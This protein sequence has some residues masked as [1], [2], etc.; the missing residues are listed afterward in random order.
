ME[1]RGDQIDLSGYGQLLMHL[2]MR[3]ANSLSGW[4]NLRGRI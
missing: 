1:N 3:G 2:S 4:T